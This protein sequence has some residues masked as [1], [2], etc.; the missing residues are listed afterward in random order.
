MA[1]GWESKAVESQQEAAADRVTRSAPPPAAG[2]AQR[3]ARRASLALAR[4]RAEADLKVASAP[5]H[6]TMLE[7]AIAALNQELAALESR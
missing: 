3:Q 1:R 4:T 7:Q 2:D 5:A 6:R